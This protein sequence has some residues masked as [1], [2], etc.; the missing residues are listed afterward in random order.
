M[1][2]RFVA[3][4]GEIGTKG[5][6]RPVFERS[7]ERNIRNT[8][9]GLAGLHVRRA[10]QR[11]LVDVEDEAATE[12]KERLARVFGLV[13]YAVVKT[14][15]L[16]Y[17]E[18]LEVAT[19]ALGD[20]GKGSTFRVSARRSDKTFAMGSQDIARKLGEDLVARLS[21]KVDL[22]HPDATLYTDI[23]RDQ[24]LLYLKRIKGLGGLPVGVSGRVLHLLSG[25][26]DS[27]AAGWMMMKRGCR[28]TYL[29][30]YLA[31]GPQHVLQSKMMELVRHLGRYSGD[32]DL[33]LIP[34]AP[35][36]LATADMPPEF[37]PVVFR[38]FV[39]MVA[40]RLAS[41]LGYPAISTGDNLAQVASQTLQN[42]VCIDSGS[43][44]PT[45][46]PLLAFDKEE[47][48]Q[49]AKQIGTYEISLREYKDCCSIISRHPKTRMKVRDVDDASTHF[50]FDELAKQC[51]SLG[52][53]VTVGLDWTTI[54][55]L[56]S[57]LEEYGR[58]GLRTAHEP[59]GLTLKPDT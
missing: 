32:S 42:L 47:I 39:R 26:I 15:P 49:M 57:L 43:S 51:I 38:R 35:Y 24:A 40:E 27:P 19:K 36:Q 12:A 53:A 14:A 54:K 28:P 37:E 31:P 33:L 10:H 5:T 34:F 17:P 56:A 8:L 16:S 25:G 11:F 20:V 21:L 23:L 4:Y 18:I 59:T 50:K 48:V 7:L 3:H 13:W 6:N 9:K 2:S 44:V 58:K 41:D 1:P 55:P 45:L 29:H 22:T 30:F 52:D 46:R